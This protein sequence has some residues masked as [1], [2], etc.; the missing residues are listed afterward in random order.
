MNALKMP[1]SALLLSWTFSG[2]AAAGTADPP[3]TTEPIENGLLRKAYDE[4][5]NGRFEQAVNLQIA[6]VKADRNNLTARRYLGYSLLKTGSPDKA[7]EQLEIAL[8]R[9]TPSAVDMCVFGEACL[10]CGKIALAQSWFEKALATDSKMES[11]RAGLRNVTAA[12]IRY[13]ERKGEEQA[14][15]ERL[16]AEAPK[17]EMPTGENSKPSAISMVANV[18]QPPT[19]NNQTCNAWES[20]KGI[21]RK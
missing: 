11:A 14:S 12:R 5:L 17:Q 8:Q 20:F 7:I 3:S 18:K 16:A 1:L 15:R 2:A 9:S 6:A 21:Q 19:S 13:E 4:M 10:Q